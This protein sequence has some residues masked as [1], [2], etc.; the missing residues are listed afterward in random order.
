MWPA[1]AIAL[2]GTASV[3]LG[4]AYRSAD[5]AGTFITAPVERGAITSVV[6]A[7]GTVEAKVRVDVSSQL[8]GQVAKVFVDFNDIVKAGQPLAQLD[9]ESFIA[10]VNETRAALKMAM[11]TARVQQGTVER[12]K[13]S[14]DDARTDQSL[15]EALAD[16]T[17]AKH[18]EAERELER[19][20]KLARTGT[21]PERD[22]TQA[23]TA[24][25]T[26]AADLRAALARVKMKSG[27]IAIAEADL[28]IA[29]ANLENAEAVVEQKK[30]ELDQAEFDLKRAVIRSPIDGVILDRDV[31]PGQTIAVSL[32][33][34]TLFTIANNLDFMEVHGRI[35]EA[36]VGK[37][38]V[39]QT[40]NFTVD[41]YPG[42]KFTGTVLQIR[43]ASK[44]VQNVITYTAVISTPNPEHLLLPGMT[45]ELRIVVSDSGPTLKI[46]NQALRFSPNTEAEAL[47]EPQARGSQPSSGT[48]ST[49]WIVGNDG[50]ATPISVQL[51]QS[52]DKDTQLLKGP[53]VEGQPL[54][55]GTASSRPERGFLGIRL[56]F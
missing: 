10:R 25:D 14:V 29:E 6:S 16:A 38:N 47:Q 35:D 54:I 7:T 30:A 51:G 52:D 32:E 12:A 34:K 53:L 2:L 3:G 21:A 1:V 45:A 44:V 4:F 56:G 40:A 55:V 19:K 22:L 50:R 42:R 31:D 9:Q 20:T 27:A 28:R 8:S 39:G 43:K 18:D 33:A 26:G 11:A 49:V 23:R 15:A 48:F 41:A 17:Q 46:P 24:R 13:L 36:D 37:L 5:D